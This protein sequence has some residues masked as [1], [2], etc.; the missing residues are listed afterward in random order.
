[1]PVASPDP[2]S[3]A[4]LVQDV[5]L[6]GR[7]PPERGE[8]VVETPVQGQGLEVGKVLLVVEGDGVSSD[9]LLHPVLAGLVG[10]A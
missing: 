6:A 9:E 5:H 2:V 4:V 10:V 8:R 3:G 1:M 7:E